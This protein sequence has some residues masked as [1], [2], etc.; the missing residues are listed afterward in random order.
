MDNSFFNAS[1]IIKAV[2]RWKKH[3]IIVGLISLGASILFSSPWFIKPKYKSYALVYPSNLIAYSNESPTEQM[4]QLAQSSDIRNWIIKSFDL[5]T[6]YD[7]DTTKNKHFLT[8]VI[9]NYDE[10]VSIRK[11]EYESMEITVYDTD[12]IVASRM[13]DSLIHYFDVKARQ[14][15]A[16]KSLEVLI[17]AGGQ[18]SQKRLQM[19]SME[20][21]LTQYRTEYGLLDYKEQTAEAT[22]GYIRA[23]TSGNSRAIK[24][25]SDLLE[26]LKQKGGELNALNELLWRI[27]GD[28][29]DIQLVYENAERDVYKKLTYANVVTS[30]QPAD[31]KSFPV[32]WLIV[33]ISV[34][35]SVLVAFMILLFFTTK[36]KVRT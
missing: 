28:Y 13:V 19:D 5:Y 32:R 10:H 30:P 31:K 22:R 27:R 12:P 4:L 26:A 2:T 17:I 36:N 6:H 25:A 35:A 8:D 29:N 1:E 3:L 11:T 16:E 9:N 14:L 20:A 7:I 34:G 33:V 24:A 21:K 18:L 15:Q 23:L